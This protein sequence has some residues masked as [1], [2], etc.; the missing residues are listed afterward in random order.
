MERSRR[1][2]ARTVVMEGLERRRVRIFWPT[3]PMAPVRMTFMLMCLELVRREYRLKMRD[4][5]CY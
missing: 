1:V 4:S 5:G 2:R 3:K